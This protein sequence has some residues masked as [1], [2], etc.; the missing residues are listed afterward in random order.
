M[1]IFVR[2]AIVVVSSVVVG[3][4][5]SPPDM[6]TGIVYSAITLCLGI[7]SFTLGR[8]AR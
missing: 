1:N 2:L 3:L 6:F 7:G 8:T 4:F 5:V